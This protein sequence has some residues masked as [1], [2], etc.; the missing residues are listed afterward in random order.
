M[1][2]RIEDI[3]VISADEFHSY[4]GEW[5]FVDTA[6]PFQ[7][8]PMAQ[9][10]ISIGDSETELPLMWQESNIFA[11]EVFITYEEGVIHTFLSL[12]LK[13]Q[14][15]SGKFLFIKVIAIGEPSNTRPIRIS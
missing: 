15:E 9:A 8:Q 11:G 13:D 14:L 7:S 10:Y 12:E 6:S 5:I 3:T 2:K 4:E 1:L